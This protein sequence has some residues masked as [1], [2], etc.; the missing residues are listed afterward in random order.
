MK[1]GTVVESSR[2]F[3]GFNWPSVARLPDGRIAAVC[4]GFRLGHVCPFG[5]AV[6]CYSSDE[7]IIYGEQY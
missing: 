3:G 6:I 4:S 2:L 1:H 7:E 5:K